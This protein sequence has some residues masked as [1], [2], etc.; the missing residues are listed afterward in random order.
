VLNKH[1]ISGG[2]AYLDCY[3]TCLQQIF[4]SRVYSKFFVKHLGE[5]TSLRIVLSASWP[6]GELTVWLAA[7]WFV[8]ELSGK[9]LSTHHMLMRIAGFNIWLLYAECTISV[10]IATLSR[11]ASDKLTVQQVDCKLLML[12]MCMYVMINASVGTE[13]VI[14]WSPWWLVH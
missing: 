10:I 11:F 13:N 4:K 6:V 12:I 2:G 5:L 7:S 3:Q 1:Q 9:P 14:H 8:S